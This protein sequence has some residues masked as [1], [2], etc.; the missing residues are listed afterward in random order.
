MTSEYLPIFATDRLM[1]KRKFIRNSIEALMH[2][3]FFLCAV[4]SVGI[5]LGI[6][7]VL[8]TEALNFF[9]SVSLLEFFTE[10]EWTPLFAVKKFG[11]LPLVC[12][13]LLTSI[14]A[15]AISLPMGLTIA[16]YLSEFASHRA[17]K[18]LKPILELLAGI[19]SVVF[20]YFALII[21]T[22]F[23]QTFIPGLSGF[24]ALSPGIVMGFM[25]LPLVAS[26]SEDALSSVP[27]TL[28]EG[29]YALGASKLQMIF[30]VILRAALSGIIAS[31][32]LAFSRAIGE[33]MIVAIAAGQQPV[34]SVN[35]LEAVETMTAYIV[36]VSL[37]DTPHG[38]LEYSTIFAVGTALFAMT[39]FLNMISLTIRQK[40]MRK[41]A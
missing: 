6:V 23:L 25:I 29:A 35:P 30:G 18:I 33:T 36:Q 13:T 11:I 22:P 8:C 26:L 32:I 15:M 40:Y 28:R 19:P 3:L 16:I 7:L 12:G 38:T 21:V 14:I 41:I 39:F 1:D 2:G 20:G 37:G 9:K 5:T 4:A 27:R 34:L 10:T 24:N 31:F 17:R